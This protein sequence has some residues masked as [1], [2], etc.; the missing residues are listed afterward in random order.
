MLI[1][2]SDSAF[3]YYITQTGISKTEMRSNAIRSSR[4]DVTYSG[5][6]D[7][8]SSEVLNTSDY[9]LKGGS[10]SPKKPGGKGGKQKR[11]LNRELQEKADLFSGS[12]LPSEV[13]GFV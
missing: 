9:S 3:T 5:D 13:A 11:D 4:L 1:L 7:R 12:L 2:I 10:D 8:P 6:E